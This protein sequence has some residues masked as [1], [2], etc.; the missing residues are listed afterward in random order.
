MGIENYATPFVLE[1]WGPPD[2]PVPTPMS[3]AA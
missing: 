2:H 3:E 1:K